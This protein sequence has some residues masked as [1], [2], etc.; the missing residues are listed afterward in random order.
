M[1]L[2]GIASF[3][4][5]SKS[6]L[7]FALVVI[8]DSLARR[9]PQISQAEAPE[10][11]S[12]RHKEL[13]AIERHADRN[14]GKRRIDRRA[15]ILRRRPGC[16]D[17]RPGG[18]PDV[19]AADTP[20]NPVRPEDDFKSIATQAR[21]AVR[22]FRSVELGDGYCGPPWNSQGAHIDLEN[23]LFGFSRPHEVKGVA[24]EPEPAR[25]KRGIDLV[26]IGVDL[27]PEIDG[28]TPAEVVVP[29]L[30]KR[31]PDVGVAVMPG[32]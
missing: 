27:R 17:M 20:W 24:A 12:L 30:A 26:L 14:L 5:E 31:D 23:V 1:L 25:Q 4:P 10:L 7:A 16:P 32:D 8:V 11:L 15:Q 22:C 21:R 6:G 19:G 2:P 18:G 9:H 28:A 29:I 3:G 13:R